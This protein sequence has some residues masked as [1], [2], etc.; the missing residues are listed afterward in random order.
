METRQ[1]RLDTPIFI[2]GA[3]SSGT[4][5]LARMFSRHPDVFCGPEASLFNK[6]QIYGDFQ[7]VKRKLC[8]WLKR[9]LPTDGYSQYFKIMPSPDSR[10]LTKEVLP[11]CAAEASSLR[12]LVDR[13]Q[14]YCLSQAGKSIYAEK[15]PSDVYCFR[16]L[17]KLYPNC[18]LI[19]AVRDGRD[20]VCSLMKRGFDVFE[21]TSIWLYNTACGIGCRDLTNYVETRYE[22]LVK[23]PESVLRPICARLSIPF[24]S[25][26][27]QPSERE[28]KSRFALAGYWKN[29]AND[30]VSQQSV[31]RHE[32]DM[33]DRDYAVFCAVQL[34]RI[35]SQK[36]GT[37]QFTAFEL[38][39]QLG[40]AAEP[41]ARPAPL[42]RV[43]Q[44]EMR[45]HLRQNKELIRR[46][47]LPR[48][49]LTQASVQQANNNR[50]TSKAA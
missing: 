26:M 21:S 43:K 12:E 24:N 50:Q 41:P 31:G 22:D 7:V 40:Y 36:T 37:S 6:R 46:G 17:A 42:L 20:V 2:G 13:I 5:L 15:T 30:H 47:Y 23:D 29:S 38:L 33:S 27:L 11:S 45:D 48:R 49:A 14:I 10:A 3:S 35:G 4:T 9:G 18:L 34:T 44:L 39:H 32:V 16:Q 8:G 19:H 25:C 28:A 1:H